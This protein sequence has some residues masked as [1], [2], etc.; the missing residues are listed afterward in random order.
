M[1][2]LRMYVAAAPER[3]EESD[4]AS[5]L[6][7]QSVTEV[8]DWRVVIVRAL[9][10]THVVFQGVPQLEDKQMGKK[11]E[12]KNTCCEVEQDRIFFIFIDD[13]NLI[14]KKILTNTPSSHFT[15]VLFE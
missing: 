10:E 7:C 5:Y 11:E 6:R 3:Q 1:D 14:A 2:K 8:Q 15:G 4:G 9:V 12:E 13:R